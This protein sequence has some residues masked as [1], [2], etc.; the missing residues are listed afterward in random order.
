[1]EFILSLFV[2]VVMAAEGILSPLADDFHIKPIP[3]PTVAQP[4][5][6]FGSL[7]AP[8]AMLTPSPAPAV[9]GTTIVATPS[10]TPSPQATYRARLKHYAVAVI[11]DSMV[12]TLGPDI[13]HLKRKLTTL[14]PGTTFTMLNYGVGATNIDLGLTRITNSYT[15]LGQNIPSLVSQSPDIV[16]IE[17]FGYNPYPF[18]E[19][20]LERHWLQM[21]A[22]VDLL[23]DRL[24]G[25]KIVIAATI[26][27][28]S[29]L[30]GDG[31]PGVAFAAQDKM[32]RTTVIKGYL[33]STV[34]FAHSQGLPLA[35]AYHASL[36]KN[37]DGNVLYINGGDHIHYS[38]QGRDLFAQKVADAIVNNKLLE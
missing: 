32:E 16:V 22:M 23:R 34:K 6:S 25:V 10:A 3:L 14:F 9:L 5:V 21:A 4:R 17:S 28:N 35:D 31:A 13:P 33:D 1:M 38:D 30:F 8:T 11:G 20:A 29:Q 19:G 26:A 2:S 24:P 36:M 18:D 12:D 37:G 7:V 15:Y 27:P